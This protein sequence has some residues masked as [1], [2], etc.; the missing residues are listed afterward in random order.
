VEP[1]MRGAAAD[2]DGYYGSLSCAREVAAASATCLLV[3][4]QV[5]DE[6]GGF[7]EEYRARHHDVDLCLRIRQLGRTVVVTP[8]AAATV[9][10]DPTDVPEDM[11][12]RAL[13]VDRWLPELDAGDPYLSPQLSFAMTPLDGPRPGLLRRIA[14]RV[15]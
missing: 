10:R 14:R 8:G 12:D 2:S 4:R 15:A 6:A 9:H 13:L 11:I 7:D 1:I 3:E 5:F